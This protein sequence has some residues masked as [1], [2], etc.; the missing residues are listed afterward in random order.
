M[1]DYAGSRLVLN[2]AGA[3]YPHTRL[4]HPGM[5]SRRDDPPI[6]VSSVLSEAAS[7]RDEVSDLLNIA[8]KA[9][10]SSES[11][12]V[13]G[14]STA[15]ISDTLDAGHQRKKDRHKK[16]GTFGRLF[17]RSKAAPQQEEESTRALERLAD[18][19]P[20]AATPSRRRVQST[21]GQDHRQF[22]TNRSDITPLVP[23]L[24]APTSSSVRPAAHLASR[25]A[26]PASHTRHP[27]AEAIS[28]TSTFQNGNSVQLDGP[29]TKTYGEDMFSRPAVRALSP[30]P[31][32]NLSGCQGS[33]ISHGRKRSLSTPN[34]IPKHLYRPQAA[35]P[36][37]PSAR[38]PGSTQQHSGRSQAARATKPGDWKEPVGHLRQVDNLRFTQTTPTPPDLPQAQYA[39]YVARDT[40]HRRNEA[41]VAL[42]SAPLAARFTARMGESDGRSSRERSNSDASMVDPAVVPPILEKYGQKSEA[43]T[44]NSP[45]R[46]LIAGP[47]G[48]P[49]TSPLPPPPTSTPPRS[50]ILHDDAE[51]AH[52]AASRRSLVTVRGREHAEQ[53]SRCE[54][55]G[56]RKDDRRNTVRCAHSSIISAYQR[57]SPRSHAATSPRPGTGD[58][59]SQGSDQYN[60]YG[61][62]STSTHS[63]ARF[64][65]RSTLE[66]RARGD[67]STVA[68]SIRSSTLGRWPSLSVD[69]SHCTTVSSCSYPSGPLHVHS[70]RGEDS[71]SDYSDHDEQQS[72]FPGHPSLTSGRQ[73]LYRQRSR[74]MFR[75]LD[76]SGVREVNEDE[77]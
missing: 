15:G 4:Q 69:G 27:H 64:S 47:I 25:N 9:S 38:D 39:R 32:D 63:S 58:S 51:L 5:A 17:T 8:R 10:H 23:P 11:D 36:P 33:R 62:S 72:R 21:S 54:E 48:P 66:G 60:E 37:L 70:D 26:S 16:A 73:L 20:D 14:V 30:S 28:P 56:D 49:P 74:E 13:Q 59:V 44:V 1:S 6:S 19:V 7:L 68:S 34:P 18:D 43:L 42:R 35:R 46:A 65:D 75:H 61:T 57:D 31:T 76:G 77:L 3:A 50:A 52:E 12:A 55:I 24:P 45:L 29:L 71:G 2:P 41:S 22:Q 53:T 67:S 40:G